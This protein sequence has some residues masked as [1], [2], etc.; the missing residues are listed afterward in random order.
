MEEF[1]MLTPNNFKFSFAQIA[2]ADFG[3]AVNASPYANY[4]E[5][6]SDGTIAGIRL[7]VVLPNNRYEKISVKL[8]GQNHPLTPENFKEDGVT[9]KV[10]FSPDFEGKFYKTSSGEYALT[11]KATNVSVIK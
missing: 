1:Q 7:E 9:Y 4:V 5:G 2:N 3:L 11:C 6:K 10:S 8:P